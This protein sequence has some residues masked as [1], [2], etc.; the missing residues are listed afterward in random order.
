MLGTSRGVF[1]SRD[2]Q[3]Q[4]VLRFYIENNLRILYSIFIYICPN[5]FYLQIF[6]NLPNVH[7]FEKNMQ[8]HI[9]V[10][11]SVQTNTDIPNTNVLI[12]LDLQND[13]DEIIYGEFTYFVK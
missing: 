2:I 13:R 11:L 3:F 7:N 5:N 9:H 12:I 10:Y 8:L 1:L 6:A 4:T